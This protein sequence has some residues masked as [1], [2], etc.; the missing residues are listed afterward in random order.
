MENL[1]YFLKLEPSVMESTFRGC[2]TAS[3]C[4]SAPMKYK[5]NQKWITIHNLTVN[6]VA[7]DLNKITV[8]EDEKDIY[9]VE[10]ELHP[11]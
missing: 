7:T 5:F 6:S 8:C 11:G 4:V 2:V 9:Q 3:F 10:V 1:E